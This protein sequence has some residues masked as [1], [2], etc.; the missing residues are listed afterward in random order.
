MPMFDQVIT[1]GHHEALY[2]TEHRPPGALLALL[3]V[4]SMELTTPSYKTEYC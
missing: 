2:A 1:I 3:P 4:S